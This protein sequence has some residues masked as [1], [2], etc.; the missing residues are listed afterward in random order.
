MFMVMCTVHRVYEY[1]IPN[2]LNVVDTF[3]NF[4]P[5]QMEWYIG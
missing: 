4:W 1:I 2:P 3:S 5:F